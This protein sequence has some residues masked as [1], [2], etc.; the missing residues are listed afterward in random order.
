[1][2][3]PSGENSGL[4]SSAGW[5]TRSRASPP[6]VGAVQRSPAETKTISLP[7]GETLGCEKLGLPAED[8]WQATDAAKAQTETMVI[9]A[10]GNMGLTGRS[11]G[12]IVRRG[13]GDRLRAAAAVHRVDCTFLH[14][15][16]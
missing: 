6:E 8:S 10:R 1:M 3:E 14:V 2:R 16:A 9:R 11:I 5:A 4:D 13:R 12:W 15:F 7:S